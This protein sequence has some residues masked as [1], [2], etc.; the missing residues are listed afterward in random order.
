MPVKR[1]LLPS[2]QDP[3]Q[4]PGTCQDFFLPSFDPFLATKGLLSLLQV[5]HTAGGERLN[6]NELHAVL[7]IL[8]L[9]SEELN[10][11]RVRTPMVRRDR[12]VVPDEGAR[13]LTVDDVICADAA[14]AS[15][16]N[17]IDCRKV[18]LTHPLLPEVVAVRLGVRKLSES[19]EEVGVVFLSHL[20]FSYLIC[21]Y[22]AFSVR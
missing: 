14:G 6:P 16:L 1:I 3:F 22:V 20:I 9:A 17:E 19:V 10:S 12:I 15:L 5:A 11:T 18:R 21:F 4:L 2:G 8:T 13:L 7:R